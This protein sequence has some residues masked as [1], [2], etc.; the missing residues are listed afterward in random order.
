[1]RRAAF[2]QIVAGG[3]PNAIGTGSVGHPHGHFAGLIESIGGW[4]EGRKSWVARALQKGVPMGKVEIM[5]P[6]TEPSFEEIDMNAEIG[7]YQG[8]YDGV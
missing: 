1:M 4:A 6:W 5:Q 7:A 3:C 8:D 2:G